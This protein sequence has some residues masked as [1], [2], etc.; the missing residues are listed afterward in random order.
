MNGLPDAN[1]HSTPDPRPKLAAFVVLVAGA[2]FALETI[3]AMAAALVYLC[4]LHA[5]AG[6][7]GGGLGAHLRRLAPAFA[8]IILLNGWVAPGRPALSVLGRDLLTR[9]GLSAG[10]FFS[11]RLAVLYLS[12]AVLV[13]TTPPEEFAAGLFALLRR[14]WPRGA[15][16][17]AF[18]GFVSM[19][20]VPLFGDEF[21][22]VRTAQSFR[23]GGLSGGPVERVRGARLLLVPLVMS[24]IHRSGQLAMVTELRGLK[25][26]LGESLA[27]RRAP[28]REAALSAATV[29]V[30]VA[31]ALWLR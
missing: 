30:V 11:L 14:V 6:R 15:R 20:F 5:A 22:R 24:A 17:L 28:A 26:R 4:V 31:A 12:T 2:M 29:A 7:P 23:G 1:L 27:L 16:R 19:S 9:E 21:H 18:Y 10:V 3:T 8:L 13:A 25:D